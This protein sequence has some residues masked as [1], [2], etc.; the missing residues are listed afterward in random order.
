[1]DDKKFSKG[2]IGTAPHI[3]WQNILDTRE[4]VSYNASKEKE[5]LIN[6]L[7]L[8]FYIN[9]KTFGFVSRK[10]LFFGI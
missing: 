8:S 3:L 9:I 2:A 1:M 10:R 6:Q 5:V 7:Y 4:N